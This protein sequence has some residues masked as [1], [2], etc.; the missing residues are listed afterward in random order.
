MAQ[1]EGPSAGPE[2]RGANHAA[3]TTAEQA[4]TEQPQ[5]RSRGQAQGQSQGPAQ[6]Q[7]QSGAQA[8]RASV[9]VLVA[10]LVGLAASSP[11]ADLPQRLSLV[12]L[13]ALAG[14]VA[15]YYTDRAV[16]GLASLGRAAGRLPGLL[17]RAAAVP[18]H[19]LGRVF[20]AVAV[21]SGST[22]RVTVSAV[23]LAAAVPVGLFVTHS[24]WSAC[25]VPREMRVAASAE[26]APAIQ[27][28][29]AEF[30]RD[31]ADWRGCRTA[32]VTVSAPGSADDL[33][34]R[35][36]NGW[37]A[38]AAGPPTPPGPHPDLWIA[39][40]AA[41]VAEVRSQVRS[42]IGTDTPVA[43]S[44]L[45]V[46][47]PAA[48]AELLGGTKPGRFTWR[49]LISKLEPR[50]VLRTHPE[51]SNVGMLATAGMY[52]GIERDP[53]ER[54]ALEAR[55]SAGV[56]W[57]ETALDVMCRDLDVAPATMPAMVLSEQQLLEFNKA[58]SGSASEVWDRP[59][60]QRAAEISQLRP[61]YPAGGHALTYRCV[62]VIWPGGS[63][64]DD[65]ARDFCRR[66]PGYLARYGFR[67]TEG[68]LPDRLGD[69]DEL[70]RN[71]QVSPG[72]R[73]K[74]ADTVDLAG[75]PILGDHVLLAIDVSG[76]MDGAIGQVGS[77]LAVATDT[78]QTIVSHMPGT[79]ST[80][81]WVF[82]SS[83]VGGH[84]PQVPLGPSGEVEA[85]LKRELAPT[86]LRTNLPDVPLRT[87]ITDALADLRGLF[88]R[89]VLVVFTDGGDT[90][91]LGPGDFA[92]RDGTEVVVL[93]TNNGC[94]LDA[95]SALE[96]HK[97]LRCYPL[98]DEPPEETLSKVVLDLSSRAPGE[99]G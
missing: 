88:G 31:T 64:T 21:L 38:S 41:E 87:V 8:A 40:S 56:G 91:G 75:R 70:R 58:R 98:G 35:L 71:A 19:A 25:P 11:L 42:L 96:K 57:A 39:D 82:P 69:A 77:R 74:V 86:G 51:T 47:V 83:A 76:S 84:A 49:E 14:G 61:L 94:D 6:S 37:Q 44:P 4:A 48:V 62:R 43:T 72:W 28:A 55:V 93:A 1:G 2:N 66:L 30:V 54:A 53:K 89:R 73:P 18:M 22:A 80:G 36:L 52:T 59:D 33:R 17:G 92:T 9:G 45:V 23:L 13:F 12:T 78:A 60:C 34:T 79:Q 97:D 50:A 10:E 67:D 99:A 20:T 5:G 85:D 90:R 26:T 95:V 63:G 32:Q 16:A 7:G 3:P 65:P 81:L 15:F 68:A 46:A 27:A 24:P 29:A